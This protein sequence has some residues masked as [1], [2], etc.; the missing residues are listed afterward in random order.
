MQVLQS[1]DYATI[2]PN[3]IQNFNII[4][5]QNFILQLKKN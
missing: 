4:G 2:M 3:C 5:P 1:A